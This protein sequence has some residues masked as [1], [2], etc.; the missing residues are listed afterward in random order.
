M[1]DTIKIGN[2]EIDNLKVGTLSV[3]ALYIGGTKLY[4]QSQPPHDYS[5]DYLTV[6]AL[7]SGNVKWS[8][9]RNGTTINKLS[10]STDGGSTWSAPSSSIAI[11]VNSGDTVSFKGECTPAS[12]KPYGIGNF[13]SSGGTWEVEGNVM[14][15][16]YGDNFSGQTTLSN[17][18]T[19]Y[20]LFK[21]CSGMTSAENLS[22]PATSLSYMCY[23]SMFTNCTSLTTAPQL[24]ATTLA[25]YC[26]QY[27]FYGCS[28]L[29]TAPT[30][31]A[32]TL[33]NYC[34][35]GMFYKCSS[36]TTAPELPAPTLVRE[37]YAYM[38]YNCSSLNSITCLATDISE[39][40]CTNSWVNGLAST[41]TFTTP[42]STNW[43][44]GTSGIPS[45]WTR[46]DYNE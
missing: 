42:S 35:N 44:T 1:A 25:N 15:L 38:F 4:P 10:Y 8:G 46:V 7:G 33:A 21:N 16:I 31:L 18:Y 45:G 43:K 39:S 34:Y 17:S 20:N 2:L 5:T 41:G 13:D 14:S 3:D 22:L 6:R 29:T 27:M 30:L 11:S 12:R 37:C 26:Y 19:F 28:G 40:Q 36:L 23:Y 32:T 9:S 24:P